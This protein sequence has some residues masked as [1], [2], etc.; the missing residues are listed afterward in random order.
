MYYVSLL[1]IACLVYICP[2]IVFIILSYIFN[3]I[4]FI[5]K[6]IKDG[7][8]MRINYEARLCMHV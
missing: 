8:K 6:R 7:N 3:K 1:I 4:I 2:Y 5:A